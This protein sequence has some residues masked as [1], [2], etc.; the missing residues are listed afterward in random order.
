MSGLWTERC[1]VCQGIGAVPT[2][3]STLWPNWQRCSWCRGRGQIAY[4]TWS[5]ELAPA[6]RSTPRGLQESGG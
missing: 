4:R 1:H 6:R 5:D 3:T 2:S